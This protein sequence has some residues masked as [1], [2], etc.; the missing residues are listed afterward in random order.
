MRVTS[1]EQ[2]RGVIREAAAELGVFGSVASLM[3]HRRRGGEWRGYWERN[4]G[5]RHWASRAGLEPR[6]VHSG[7][8]AW[9]EDLD[10][11]V[12]AIRPRQRI[13]VHT[14]HVGAG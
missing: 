8:H 12:A 11:L 2:A 14:D 9:P 5:M 4:A 1:Y 3:A 7:G 13:W 10:R 6:F